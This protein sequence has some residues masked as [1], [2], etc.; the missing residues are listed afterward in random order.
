MSP[1]KH[2]GIRGLELP[3]AYGTIA[4]GEREISN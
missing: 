2:P 3:E 4:Y 1:F